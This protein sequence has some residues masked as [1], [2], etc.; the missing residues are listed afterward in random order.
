MTITDPISDIFTRIRNALQSKHA[1]V[2]LP[3]SKI[4]LSIVKILESEGFIQGYELITKDLVKRFVSV[5]LKYNQKGSGVIS[6]IQRVSTPGKRIYVAK[7]KVP[8]VLN[9]FGISI[10]STSKGVMTG[11][12]ARINNVGGELIG[13]VY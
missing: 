7:R 13:E 3:L 5:E 12:E 1:A 6:S 9:G 11:R 2:L 8:K 10:L 4:T